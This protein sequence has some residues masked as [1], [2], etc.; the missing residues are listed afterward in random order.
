MSA[1]PVIPKAAARAAFSAACLL[2]LAIAQPAWS[3]VR[4]GI[5][6][7]GVSG[8]IDLPS[9]ASQPDGWLNLT[10]GTFGPISRNNLTFQIIPRLSGSFRYTGIRNWNDNF[11]PPNCSGANAFKTYYDRSFDL[12]Y[13]ILDEGRYLPSVTIGLQDFIGTSLNMGEYVVASKSIGPRLRV[14]AG[15]GFG[16]LASNGGRPGPFGERPDVDFGNGGLPNVGQW[17]RGDMAPFGGIEYQVSDRWTFKAEYSSDAYV[18]EAER[19]GTF[20]Y[21]SPLNFGLE[22]Q[23]SPMIRLGAYSMHGSELGFSVNVAINPRQRPTGGMRGT[24]PL[25]L[26]PRP[27]AAENPAAWS[28]AW[29]AQ[30]DGPDILIQNLMLNLERTGIVIESIQLSADRA[31]VRYRNTIYDAPSQAA[32]RVARAMARVLPA[33]IETFELVPVVHSM[34]ASKLVLRRG[35]LEELEFSPDQ[36]EALRQ[37]VDLVSVRQAEPGLVRNDALYPAFS[38][39]LSP[40]T[41]TMFFD[42]REPLQ[43]NLG[44]EL[45]ARVRPVPGIVLSGSVM[46]SLVDNMAEPRPVDPN[47]PL[48]PVRSELARYYEEGDLVLGTLTA[49]FNT[50]LAPEVYGRLTVGYLELMYAGVSGEVLWKPVEGPLALGLEANYVRQRNSDGGLGLDQYDYGVFTG[51]ASAYLDLGRDYAI[52]LDAG[53]YL[54]GDLGATFALMRTFENG[55]QVGAYASITNVSAEDFG[56]GSFDKGLTF[57][58]PLTWLTGHPTRKARNMTIQPI[59]RD[60]GARLNVRDRLH[61]LL[62]GTDQDAMDQQWERFWK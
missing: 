13:R 49:A 23:L 16:R 8:I 59:G 30:P 31:Q 1:V 50:K 44:L 53:R 5:N 33:S 54:A 17:F 27:S 38:W 21:R 55:W 25:P 56:E 39:S 41:Q 3:E 14:T 22:Y 24:A 43:Y 9:A 51:H 10:H 42:P 60:G 62:S 47:S 46:K 58:L 36:G 11:C 7:S 32:G 6:L 18:Q 48:H 45:S 34:A 15:L 61:D 37:R 20:D 57:R 28:T 2:G 35:D 26:I 29:T 40:F 19:R 12:S 4:P 52:R